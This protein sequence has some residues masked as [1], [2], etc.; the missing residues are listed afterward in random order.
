M[1]L[2]P[3]R[4][5]AIW[6]REGGYCGIC[7]E[8]VPYREMHLDHIVPVSLGGGDEPGNL[9]PA[10]AACNIRRGNGGVPRTVAL[11]PGAAQPLMLRMPAEVKAWLAGEAK[12]GRRSFAGQ[13]TLII[14]E[15]RA[16]H[17]DGRR[18]P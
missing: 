16:S 13:V 1:A 14:E 10:H 5:W 2:T 17:G 3:E 8:P 11:R 15:W 12:R 4:R 9:R 6:G 7:Y 18:D